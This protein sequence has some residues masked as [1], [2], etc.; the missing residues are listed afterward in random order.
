MWKEHLQ[1]EIE[2]WR[3]LGYK[4]PFHQWVVVMV[5]MMMIMMMIMIISA[6]D[7]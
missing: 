2:E 3:R 4:Q 6:K 5:V 7:H 1:Y